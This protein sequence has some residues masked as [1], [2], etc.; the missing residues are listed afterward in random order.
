MLLLWYRFNRSIRAV[1]LIKT[2]ALL[3]II[4][5]IVACQNPRLELEQLALTNNYRISDH[6]FADLPLVQLRKKNIVANTQRLRVYIEGDGRA[7]ITQSQPSLDPT[8]HHLLMTQLAVA[9]LEPNIYLARPC[10]FLTHKNCSVPLW[11]SARFGD[12]VL[13]TMHRALDELRKE[14]KNTEFELIGYSGGA[15]IALLLATQRDDVTQIQTVAGNLSPILWAQFHKLTPL[16]NSKDPINYANNLQYIKQR[17]FIGELDKNI[18]I[19]LFQ[20]YIQKLSTMADCMERVDVKGA[21]HSSGWESTWPLQ[22][23]QPI[24]CMTK[25]ELLR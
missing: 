9:D 14:L 20:L 11:T 24:R 12:S 22:V 25:Q 13:V 17:H 18:S 2:I 3:V 16:Y 19:E 7:W 6:I 15:A 10:Q 4:S 8:P 1:N 21:D 23:N 5:A